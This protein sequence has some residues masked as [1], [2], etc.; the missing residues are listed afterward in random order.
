MHGFSVAIQSSDVDISRISP[1]LLKP[2]KNFRID[3]ILQNHEE[4]GLHPELEPLVTDIILRTPDLNCL[5][6]VCDEIYQDVFGH[7]FFDQ[8]K[9]VPFFK[10]FVK[11]NED[12]LSPNYATLATI[13]EIR[14]NGCHTYIVLMANGDQ[15]GKFL[16]FGD[17]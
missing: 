1:A 15:V 9:G 17:K 7:Y 2:E 14:R 5:A 6:V 8:L 10:V 12:L 11:E 16:R 4:I 13:R 3:G